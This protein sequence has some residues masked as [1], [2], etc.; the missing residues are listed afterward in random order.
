M[1]NSAP[2][3][4]F[5]FIALLRNKSMPK[6]YGWVREVVPES[7]ADRAGLQPGDLIRTING[8]ML[9][10]LVDYRFYAADEELV[11]GFERQ[12]TAHEVRIIKSI[13]ENLGVLFGEEPAPFIR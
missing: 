13:D 12:L 9:H 6:M 1:S 4:F 10:D 2:G 5:F 7:P 3:A 8:N 11:I